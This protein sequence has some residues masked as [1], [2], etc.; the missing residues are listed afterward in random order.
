MQ[1]G[2][3]EGLQQKEFNII[4]K[5]ASCCDFYIVSQDKEYNTS[6]LQ[7]IVGAA[8]LGGQECRLRN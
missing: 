4:V 2:G 1:K 7:V 8:S 5:V 6:S 3:S